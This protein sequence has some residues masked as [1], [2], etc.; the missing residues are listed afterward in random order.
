MYKKI[1][2][3]IVSFGLVV[4][5]FAATEP[6]AE[7]SLLSLKSFDADHS[8]LLAATPA[9]SINKINY[10]QGEFDFLN[11]EMEGQLRL[12]GAPDLPTTSTF[13]AVPAT[14]ELQTHFSY[15]SV[16]VESNVDLAPF[17]PVQ[18][19]A[20]MSSPDFAIDEA[21]YLQDAWFPASPVILH[22]R[23]TM[24][25]LTLVNLEVSPFQYNPVRQELRV[26][27]GL[28]VDLIHEP[29]TTPERPISRFFAPIYESLVPNSPLVLEPTYQTPSILYIHTENTTVATLLDA[30]KE[31][32]HQKG[33]EVHSAS[34]LQTGS[35][36]SAIKS[37]IQ[38][39]YNTWDN[40]PEFVVLVG[41]AGGTFNIPTWIESFS[42]YNG[43]GDLPY[44]H[45]AGDDYI[46]DAFV[47]R[48]PFNSIT[49][50]TNIVSKILNYEKYPDTFD[51]DWYTR[52]LLVGD[53]ASSGLSTIMTNRNINEYMEPHGFTDNFQVYGGSFVNQMATGLNAGVSYF[54]YRGWLGMSG[55]GNS[56]TAALTNGSNLPFVTILTCGTGSFTGD[57]RSEQFLRVGTSSV[58]KGAIAAV[59]TAT[60]G[61]HTLYNNCVSVGIYHGLFSDGLHYAGAALER[62]RISL[63]QT[64]PSD[65]GNYVKI[66][67][68]WNSLMGDPATELWTGVPEDIQLN[69]TAQIPEDAHFLD[70]TVLDG[71]NNALSDAW[72]TL[73]GTDVF[74]S[75]YTDA[76][77]VVVLDLPAGMVPGTMT[78]TATK[79]NYKPQQMEVEASSEAFDVLI[80]VVTLTETT[81]NGDGLLNPGETAQLALTF[82]NQSASS[83]SNVTVTVEAENAAPVEYNYANLISGSAITVDDQSFTLPLDYPAIGR[84]DV[85][86]AVDI[87]GSSYSDHRRFEVFAPHIQVHDLTEPGLPPSSFDPGEVTNVVIHGENIG[88]LGSSNLMATLRSSDPNIE[89]LDSVAFF[90]DALPGALTNNSSSTFEIDINT[91]VTVGVQVPMELEFTDDHGFVEVLSILLP[92]GTPGMED[93]TG[94]DAGGYFCYDSQD[95]AYALAPTYNWVEIVPGQGGYPGTLVPLSDNADN[96]EDIITVNLPFEFG[97]YGENYTQVSICS[98]GYIALGASEVALFRNYQ[99][100]G[101]LGPNPMIAPFWDDLIMGSGDVYTYSN[102]SEHTFTITYHNMQSAYSGSTQKFQVIL[103]DPDYYGSTD[104][105]GDIKIQYHTYNNDNDVGVGWGSSAHGQYS[106]TGLEDHTG[107]IGMQYTFNNMWAET[108]HELTD[109]SA[110]FFT[111]RTDAILPCPGWG[112]GDINNDGYRGVQDLVILINV[113]LGEG[114]FGECEFW[115]ADKSLDSL[116][117][118]SDVVLLVDE[119]MG[120]GLARASQGEA[121]SAEFTVDNGS[122]LL[123][124]SEPIKGFTFTMNTTTKPSFKEYPGLS[125]HSRETADGYKVLGYWSGDAPQ[126]VKILET[127]DAHFQVTHQQVAGTGGSLMR[128]GVTSIPEYFQVTSVYPNPFNPTVNITY[129]L[130][131]AE[132]VSIRIFNALGQEVIAERNQ[133]PAGEHVYSWNGLDQNNHLVGSGIYF[134]RISTA[135]ASQMVK[136]TY[137]R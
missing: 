64:Y 88:T 8:T 95:L 38:T 66:F 90:A 25:D 108:A 17:Q 70:V 113:M 117:T 41:D 110:L 45:L 57:S 7:G 93:P 85:A 101:P 124:A 96:Q 27:E 59:G 120:F 62:G 6:I 94:P 82:S 29:L 4:G 35:S 40:P 136:L 30:L 100:P 125:L 97:F 92:I 116:I 11:T 91:Q 111:T 74:V 42:N 119:I 71:N 102:I 24:R 80:D 58:P 77:G 12:I 63:N 106:T 54:N 83:V 22:E 122:L 33:F 37:Y 127:Q 132:E 76:D 50:F 69:A 49:E 89:V 34:T 129:A 81:G 47:G 1:L 10:A 21:I 44:A 123:T 115:A 32:R 3:I 105:N 130:P 19:E 121:G 23:V 67:S 16:R 56:N 86:I 103:Y 133:L 39:A 52:A 2:S 126:A 98:N 31:W 104:G 84:F 65:P 13:L 20:E 5:L 48:L 78:L 61:T 134:A 15:T 135:G 75:G 28:E 112:R 114:E 26:Y 107:Q 87:D 109:E 55:W 79:H 68:H 99:V 14:G 53:Q 128:S 72:V 118:I 51:T 36:N 9:Y 43:E 137:L 131:Q 18:L 60:S 73:T 46:A